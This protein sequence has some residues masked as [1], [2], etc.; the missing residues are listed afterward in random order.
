MHVHYPAASNPGAL[1]TALKLLVTKGA[2]LRVRASFRL[3]EAARASAKL[4]AHGNLLPLRPSGKAV[5]EVGDAED[6]DVLIRLPASGA[7]SSATDVAPGK[8]TE[9]GGYGY[10]SYGYAGTY[11]T[12]PGKPDARPAAS[13][14]PG[15]SSRAAR[16][17]TRA[18]PLLAGRRKYPGEVD[19]G[20]ELVL[21]D[22]R[23]GEGS[24]AHLTLAAR[25]ARGGAAGG[26]A[27]LVGAE[28]Q[29]AA[30]G[31]VRLLL[32]CDRLAAAELQAASQPSELKGGRNFVRAGQDE[33]RQPVG[34]SIS[35]G[36]R[37]LASCLLCGRAFLNGGAR[38]NH[39]RSCKGSHRPVR[40]DLELSGTGVGVTLTPQKLTDQ[41][42]RELALWAS[43]A[44]GAASDAASSA[45][46]GAAS[47]TGYS[48][49]GQRMARGIVSRE[50]SLMAASD[51][52][53]GVSG[54]GFRGVARLAQGGYRASVGSAVIGV[55]VTPRDA[56]AAYA[57]KLLPRLPPPG[58]TAE[59]QS[60]VSGVPL[61][62][63]QRRPGGRPCDVLP[64]GG[65]SKGKAAAG[66][67]RAPRHC[68]PRCSPTCPGCSPTHPGCNPTYPLTRAGAR[69]TAGRVRGHRGRGRRHSSLARAE[70]RQPRDPG[71]R[72]R[73]RPR[74][75]QGE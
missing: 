73:L 38:A 5:A 52:A 3:S 21:L 37:L 31:G 22:A 63:M 18:P 49:A 7:S 66:P 6:G 14:A 41:L 45:A 51:A 53:S 36:W 74:G 29:V 47:G 33:G 61:E 71:L 40:L 48:A 2:V 34:T 67:V 72:R 17:Q 60:R 64:G 59:A 69:H 39:A 46:S 58:A 26:A 30:G 11:G 25:Q 65:G 50:L 43:A 1:K 75:S 44:S 56:A 35:G 57:R 15:A 19:P 10:R 23:S 8:R 28:L 27:R 32:S 54:T 42:P 12:R 70:S 68:T 9:G 4:R 20:G 24:G 13:A 55:F 16:L 62:E